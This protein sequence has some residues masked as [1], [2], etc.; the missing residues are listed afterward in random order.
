MEPGGGQREGRRSGGRGNA[1]GGFLARHLKLDL[2]PLRESR[3]LRSLF[4]GGGISFAG[5]MLTYVALPY[6]TYELTHSSLVVGLL[7]LA[8]LVP[9]LVTAFI[10]GA[11][12]DAVDR[13]RMVR[14]TE[15]GMC[16][17]SVL[18][19]LNAHLAHPR[20]WVL[21][22]VSVLLTAFDGLQ[23][24]SL[25]AMVPM[26]VRP[27]QLAATS[28]IMSLR[29]QLGMIAA[30]ALTGVIIAAGGLTLTYTLDVASFVI[31]LAFML[32]L[33]AMPPPSQSDL[34]LRAM[35]IGLAYAWQR[36]DLLGTYLVDINAMFFGI[37]NA[38]FPQLASHLGGASALGVLYASPALGAFLVTAT[39]S[40]VARVRRYGRMIAV[41]AAL[42]GAGIVLL[43]FA[44]SLSL[45]AL[46]LVIAGAGDMI[47]G[48]GRSTVWNQS[49]PDDL[50][51]RLAGIEMLSYS[52]GPTL[53]NVEAGIL[54]RL[55]GLR[56]SIV[57]GGALC[58][59]GTA[60]LSLALPAFWHYDA[61]QGEKHRQLP[62]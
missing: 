59:A 57:A 31:S 55:V 5:S 36:K 48:L 53:G 58:V 27:D 47:S 32:R 34:S 44:A 54:E 24:P 9:L 8:E 10:G 17:V 40:W 42:W 35:R 39:S 14:L 30:P 37:P 3:D 45:A 49:I 2:S 46:G 50:R 6:Q 33:G 19:V 43:G 16:L 21:F 12:A 60:L 11:L 28:S 4:A 62:G 1:A 7:S 38:L 23:R 29:S 26:L 41:A 20:L 56:T 25:D 18:L 52:S 15:A 13:R 22:A 61:R 51:G